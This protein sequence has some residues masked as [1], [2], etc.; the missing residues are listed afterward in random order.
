M[1]LYQKVDWHIT[2]LRQEI[3]ALLM[4]PNLT[5]EHKLEL[6]NMEQKAIE[7]GFTYNRQQAIRER[8]AED[9]THSR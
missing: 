6:V 8:I 3:I 9:E 2:N 7:I 5:E 1:A 4:L